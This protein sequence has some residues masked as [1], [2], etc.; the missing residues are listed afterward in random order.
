MN[1][2]LMSAERKFR[3]DA[4][5]FPCAPFAAI[6]ANATAPKA[7]LSKETICIRAADVRLRVT[8][9]LLGCL[10]LGSADRMGRR[11]IPAY[12]TSRQRHARLPGHSAD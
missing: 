12:P 9:S 6:A 7:Q 8:A 3:C 5:Y 2:C 4:S 1:G 11:V 10:A